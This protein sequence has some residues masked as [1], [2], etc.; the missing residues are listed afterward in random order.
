MKRRRTLLILTAITAIII[1]LTLDINEAV[2]LIQK[3]QSESTL[4]AILFFTFLYITVTVFGLP[5]AALLAISSGIIFGFGKGVFTAVFASGISAVIS[6]LAARY[7]L[8][9]FVESRFQKIIENINH[10]IN[11]EG[12]F[13]LFFLRTVPGIP[14]TVLN[15]CFGLTRMNLIKYWCITQVAML[16]MTVLLVNAGTGITDISALKGILTVKTVISLLGIGL[17]PLII[18]LV[19]KTVLKKSV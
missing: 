19:H 6:F 7:L 8:R 5:G 17:I 14:F 12:L 10:G 2:E 4:T 16:P 3:F 11:Q 1:L 18:K 9:D 13:Y 15:M